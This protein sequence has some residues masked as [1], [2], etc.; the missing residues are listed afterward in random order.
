MATATK[1]AQ[2]KQAIRERRDAYQGGAREVDVCESLGLSISAT[3]GGSV[4]RANAIIRGVK[5]L[6]KHS[7]NSHQMSGAQGTI[8]EESAHNQLKDL[9]ESGVPT[10]VGHPPK[11]NPDQE[12][13]PRDRNGILLNPRII[14]G[15]T[16]ADWKLIPSHELTPSILDCAENDQLHSMY[17][18]SINARAYGTVKNNRY[19]VTEFMPTPS[20]PDKY[21]R[22]VDLVTRGGANRNLFE[23]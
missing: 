16:Y 20:S 12:R 17:A 11:D 6:G 15:E 22:G 10:N 3:N 23:N 4:D 8:Y 18:L 1:K 5:V 7:P 21:I 2:K 14:N 13:H 9:L 19:C